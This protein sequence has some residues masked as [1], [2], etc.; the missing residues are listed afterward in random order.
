MELKEAIKWVR[1]AHLPA[2]T[3]NQTITALQYIA[4]NPDDLSQKDGSVWVTYRDS[5]EL[6]LRFGADGLTDW[7]LQSAG[8]MKEGAR[9]TD[10]VTL[11]AIL[12]KQAD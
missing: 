10:S 7:S 5:V 12:F 2:I 9:W 1:E 6:M 3:E 11:A 4:R 8:H